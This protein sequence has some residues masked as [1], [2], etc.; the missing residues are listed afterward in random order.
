MIALDELYARALQ[1]RDNK[2]SECSPA[3]SKIEAER[4]F[5]ELSQR[6]HAKAM[7]NYAMLQQKKGN[8]E[9]AKEWFDKAGLDASKRNINLMKECGKIK[10][11]LYLVVANDRSEAGNHGS[12]ILDHVYGA[13]IDLTHLHSFGGE[14]TTCDINCCAIPGTKHIIADA[15]TFDFAKKYNLKHVLLEPPPTINPASPGE[16]KGIG[17]ISLDTIACGAQSNF[18]GSMVQNL[19]KAME[20]GAVLEIEWDPYTTQAPITSQKCEEYH[21]LD[22]FHGYMILNAGVLGVQC[23]DPACD[24]SIHTPQL[25]AMAFDAAKKFR[26]EIEFWHSQGGGS[27]LQEIMSRML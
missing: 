4:L 22:P 15:L 18:L 11:D 9:L 27:S 13:T 14:A 8:Y 10:E 16:S 24:I 1:Y 3:D 21:I 5:F 20:P 7:H 23:M 26:T 19:S 17:S 6:G 2:V 25:Q 12:P